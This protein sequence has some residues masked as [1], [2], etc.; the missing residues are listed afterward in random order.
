[1]AISKTLSRLGALILALALTP[2]PAWPQGSPS[3]PV[4][5]TLPPVGAPQPTAPPANGRPSL[6]PNAGD[7][8]DVDEVT[9]PAKPAAVLAG[10]STWDDGFQTLKTA[11]GRIEAEL[12]KAGIAPA[13]RPITV[14]V[15]TDD[16][17]F[18]YEAMVPIERAPEGRPNLTPDIRFGTTPS[19]RALRFVHKGPYDDV[20]STYETVTTYLDAK[21]IEVQDSFVEEYVTDLTSSEDED[22]TV[23]IFALPK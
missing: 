22:L 7:P 16:N 17:G 19:G 12:A 15:Q 23:N 1:M 8:V 13:G 11:F 2:A 4:E 9:L 5:P 10:T 6:V 18:R 14:F 21:N 20:D 3:G